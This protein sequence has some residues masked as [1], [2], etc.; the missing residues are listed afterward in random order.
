[1]LDYEWQRIQLIQDRSFDLPPD[2]TTDAPFTFPTL[3]AGRYR[4]VFE[5][6]SEQVNWFGA[7]DVEDVV[8]P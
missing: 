7:T 3:P 6:V 1:M 5:L 8:V 4:L 2:S